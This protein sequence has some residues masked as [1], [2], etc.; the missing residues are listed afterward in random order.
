MAVTGKD[1]LDGRQNAFLFSQGP[2]LAR[3]SDS[4][5]GEFRESLDEVAKV[6]YEC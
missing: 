5:H 1:G 3:Q 2:R 4:G 6:G